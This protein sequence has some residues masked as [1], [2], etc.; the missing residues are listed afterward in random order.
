[1]DS[2]PTSLMQHRVEQLPFWVMTGRNVTLYGPDG[3]PLPTP[4]HGLPVTRA[5]LVGAARDVGVVL[6]TVRMLLEVLGR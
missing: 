2:G 3:R 6:V 5:G 1:V 4:K